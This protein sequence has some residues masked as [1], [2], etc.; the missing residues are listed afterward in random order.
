MRGKHFKASTSSKRA[1]HLIHGSWRSAGIK[2]ASAGACALMVG[3]MLLPS[4]VLA[5]ELGGEADATAAAPIAAAAPAAPETGVVA[6]STTQGE[7]GDA[8]GG[9]ADEPAAAGS[10]EP[11]QQPTADVQPATGQDQGGST[12]V[13]AL[14]DTGAAAAD[15]ASSAGQVSTQGVSEVTG[16]SNVEV[17]TE[18]VK[19]CSEC[20]LPSNITLVKGQPYIFDFPDVEDG[21]PASC[22]DKVVETKYYRA[23][24]A[25]GALV[26]VE[27]ESKSDVTIRMEPVGNHVRATL[28][29][30][31]GVSGGSYSLNRSDDLYIGSRLTYAGTDYGDGNIIIG[32]PDEAFGG[33]G[34]VT[35]NEIRDDFYISYRFNSTVKLASQAES[36]NSAALSMGYSF[37]DGDAPSSCAGLANYQQDNDKFEVVDQYWEEMDGS[38]NPVKYWHSNAEENAKVPEAKRLTKFEEG[39]HYMFS[40]VLRQ[41]NGHEF[42]SDCAVTV[43]DKTL[44]ARSIHKTASGLFLAPVSSFTCEAALSWQAIDTIEI[45]GAAT[46]FKAGDKPVFTAGTPDGS[47]TIFQCEFWMGDDGSDANSV[48][49]WDENITNHIGTFKAGVTYRYGLYLKPAEG[50]FFTPDTKLVINGVEHGYR[51]SEA[52]VV[53]PESGWIYA[54]WLDSDITFT[55]ETTTAP[56]P[57]KPASGPEQ[58]PADKGDDRKTEPATDT[59]IK[60]AKST[61]TVVKTTTVEKGKDAKSNAVL[62]ATGDD[63]LLTVVAMGVAGAT[64]AAIGIAAT[65]RRE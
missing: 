52:S 61:T 25:S 16:G 13:A 22:H 4:V 65:K 56:D 34:K 50:F 43:N 48:A 51:V 12:D 57:E 28:V 15:G 24:A 36:I 60:D 35:I 9:S 63:A 2:I 18:V 1:R 23:D 44:D 30:T 7:S 21:I 5:T 47:N 55:P 3:Q 58:K 11:V 17:K 32:T 59:S 26:E 14:P 27:D 62:A 42:S 54:L 6:A 29:L 20:W 45:T 64:A 46:T 31:G 49:F 38:G 53:D 19:H 10:S 39:K 8:T 40:L 41:K 33:D 37:R